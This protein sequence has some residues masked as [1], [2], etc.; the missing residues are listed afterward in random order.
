MNQEIECGEKRNAQRLSSGSSNIQEGILEE[1]CKK[2][3]D[4]DQP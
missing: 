1:T 3:D 4:K 2:G